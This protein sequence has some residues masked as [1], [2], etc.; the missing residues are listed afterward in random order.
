MIKNEEGIQDLKILN[1]QSL[2]LFRTLK[3]FK[4]RWKKKY[5][6]TLAEFQTQIKKISE[7]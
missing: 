6:V 1:R 3:N 4:F 2:K 5:S 7:P